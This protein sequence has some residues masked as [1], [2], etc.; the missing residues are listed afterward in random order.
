MTDKPELTPREKRDREDRRAK[1]REEARIVREWMIRAGLSETD[2]G[3]PADPLLW[4]YEQLQAQKYH[5]RRLGKS[6]RNALFVDE[7]YQRVED[8]MRAELA[9]RTQEHMSRCR[10]ARGEPDPAEAT[11]TKSELT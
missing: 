10:K 4:S 5:L 8:E 11:F 9:R 1:N 3:L 7:D 6:V 2:R